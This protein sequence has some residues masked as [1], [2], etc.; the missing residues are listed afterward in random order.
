MITSLNTRSTLLSMHIKSWS[1]SQ[2]GFLTI[3][4]IFS[5]SEFIIAARLSSSNAIEI[6]SSFI[7]SSIDISIYGLT[8][9]TV[10]I[11]IQI[12]SFQYYG[13]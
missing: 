8:S 1:L 13:M 2:L 3:S 4:C 9:G 10:G 5:A 11:P 7:V 6:R 12:T